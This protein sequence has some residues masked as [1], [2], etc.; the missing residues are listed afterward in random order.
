[1]LAFQEAP[2]ETPAF[3]KRNNLAAYSQLV[4][5]VHLGVR[6]PGPRA[7]VL[8]GPPGQRLRHAHAVLVP[9]LALHHVREDLHVAVGVSAKPRV[10]LRERG[11][12]V[13]RGR[14]LPRCFNTPA[15]GIRNVIL[16]QNRPGVGPKSRFHLMVGRWNQTEDYQTRG[17]MNDA[18]GFLHMDEGQV[19]TA[20]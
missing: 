18:G 19:M 16:S 4:P 6:D 8:R 9:Q 14:V 3:K 15:L 13:V 2:L 1:M 20:G 12:R 7:E 11:R 10:G 5:I 17:T